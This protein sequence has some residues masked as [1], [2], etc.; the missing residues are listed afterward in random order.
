MLRWFEDVMDAL[1]Q[2]NIGIAMWNLKGEFGILN[3]N[4]KDVDYEDYRG[5]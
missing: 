2:S 4:R 5:L 1:K 3:S